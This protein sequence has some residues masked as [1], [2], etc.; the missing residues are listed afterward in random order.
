MTR[1]PHFLVVRADSPW[2][3]LKDIIEEAKKSPGKLTCSSAGIYGGTGIAIELF[4]KMAGINITHVPTLGSA[5][6]VTALL[7]GHVSMSSQS[8]GATLPHIQSGTLRMIGVYEKERLKEFP[9][10]PTFS[11]W[12]Y[13]VVISSGYGLLA[14]K[15]TP[16]EVVKTIY[17]ATEKAFEIHK[18]SIE[19]VVKKMS[20]QIDLTNPEEYG[21]Y[22]KAQ[23][24]LFKKIIS[25]LKKTTK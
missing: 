15:G 3:T 6:A 17:K 21:N 4:L 25:E 9:E 14:P 20:L 16:E 1:S 23:N 8:F 18:K 12:G 24:E 13:P 11:E 5:P 10:V 22:L 2:K 19:D 7:G